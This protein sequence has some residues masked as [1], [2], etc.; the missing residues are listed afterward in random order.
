MHQRRAWAFSSSKLAKTRPAGSFFPPKRRG[1]SIRPFRSGSFD[2]VGHEAEAQAAGEG[3]HLGG[4]DRVGSAAAGQDHAGVV[5]DAAWACAVHEQRG[6]QQESACTRKRVKRGNTERTG[7]LNTPASSAAALR[8]HGLAGHLHLGVA[9]C[10][11]WHL[12]AR[13]EV[14]LAGSSG[15]L[16]QFG[17]AHPA[18]QGA[19]GG[20]AHPLQP[21]SGPCARRCPWLGRRPASS[22]CGVATSG[23]AVARRGIRRLTQDGPHGVAR[24]PQHRLI[25][26]RAKPW[27]CKVRTLL[28]ISI[29]STAEPPQFP[30][31]LGQ[32]GL[33]PGARRAPGMAGPA[34][35]RLQLAAHA[36]EQRLRWP[37]SPTTSRSGPWRRL[38]AARSRSRSA[39]LARNSRGCSDHAVA[40]AALGALVVA[41]P[42][43]KLARGQRLRLRPANN[44]VALIGVGARQRREDAR[45]RP[46][47]RC[48]EARQP[49]PASR[50]AR[51]AASGGAAPKLAS[52]AHWRAALALRIHPRGHRSSLAQQQR[53]PQ[54]GERPRPGTRP[55]TAPAP[56]LTARASIEPARCRGRVASA[57]PRAGTR[58]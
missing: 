16:A 48:R 53:P 12:L 34:C 26:R 9:R 36:V 4:D 46:G 45:R 15:R 55:A 18:R 51:P 52:R 13:G 11:C 14:V 2:A 58:R 44:W 17:L 24:Q 41:E 21:G 7:A 25:S 57:R 32:R 42:G 50:A 3:G 35:S 37:S 22:R 29:G 5:D 38:R 40:L 19:V 33:H 54:G 43:L 39:R 31:H 28:R 49:P 23:P 56:K 10:S 8:R 6:L 1:G 27:A 20:S 30:G 47:P